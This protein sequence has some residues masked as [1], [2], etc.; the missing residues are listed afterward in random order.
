MRPIILS[1]CVL[2]VACS[3]QPVDS[4]TGPSR[5]GSST[6]SSAGANVSPAQPDGSRELPFHGSFTGETRGAVNCPPECNPPTILTVTGTRMGTATYLGAFTAT[7]VDVVDLATATGTG[8][9]N[10]TAAN[11]DQL[12]T[13]TIGGEDEFEPP[14]ISHVL[15]V[16]TIL[17]GTGRFAG[18]TGTFTV[19]TRSVI[20]FGAQTS[21]ETGSF[22]GHII[23]NK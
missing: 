23:L 8:T 6:S 17:G 16:G 14:N 12:F 10:L 20:D 11:G 1:V 7:N 5:V 9:F 21:T 19:R 4:P 22:D 2:T 18:A 15:V 3:G 13:T